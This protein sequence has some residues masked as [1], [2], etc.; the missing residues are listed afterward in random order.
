MGCNCRKS[1]SPSN[2][3]ARDPRNGESDKSRTSGISPSTVDHS[4]VPRSPVYGRMKQGTRV[5]R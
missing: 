4:V 1:S 2:L 5:K 3:G